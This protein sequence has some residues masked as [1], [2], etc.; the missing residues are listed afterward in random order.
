MLKGT[1]PK[2]AMVGHRLKIKFPTEIMSVDG[3]HGMSAKAVLLLPV[4]VLDASGDLRTSFHL[5]V[6]ATSSK[7]WGKKISARSTHSRIEAWLTVQLPDKSFRGKSAQLQLQANF[8]FP[9]VIPNTKNFQTYS[10]TA[11]KK[12]DICLLTEEQEKAYKTW[13]AARCARHSWIATW[14][15]VGALFIVVFFFVIHVQD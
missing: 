9:H 15:L 7:G 10:A 11:E 3:R 14:I 1:V 6:V 13:D 8:G 4:G 2:V 5:P 12:I